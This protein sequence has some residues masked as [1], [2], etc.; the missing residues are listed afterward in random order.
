MSDALITTPHTFEVSQVFSLI[1]MK[2][3]EE[4]KKLIG[5]ADGD[6]IFSPGGS[7]SNMYGMILARYR[8]FPETKTKGLH[9]L[10]VLV[11]FTSEAAS[12]QG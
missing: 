8:R 3:I 6:G 9:G 2:I 11:A 12:H 7:I 1:E 4:V 5:Y 10:P